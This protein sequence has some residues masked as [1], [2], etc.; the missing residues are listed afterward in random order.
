MRKTPAQASIYIVANPSADDT[1][2]VGDGVDTVIFTFKA[3]AGSAT[4][5]TIGG[6]NDATRANLK[7]KM[8]V[9]F[10]DMSGFSGGEDLAQQ[11]AF[12]FWPAKGII[13]TSADVNWRNNGFDSAVN[14]PTASFG[15]GLVGVYS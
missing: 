7:T 5:V 1:V 14:F 15:N 6:D 11:L 9:Q 2:T 13:N 10:P 12:G 8:A 3:S 4:E